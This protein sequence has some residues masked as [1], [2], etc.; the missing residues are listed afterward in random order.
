[1][2]ESFFGPNRLYTVSGASTDISKFGH[3]VFAWYIHRDL[4]AIPINPK[5]SSIL[6]IPTIKN[7]LE[8]SPTT[9]N[10]NN[11]ISIIEEKFQNFKNISSAL[12]SLNSG[13]SN[14]STATATTTISISVITPPHVSSKLLQD[15]N[16]DP[17]LKP[18]VKAIW[19]QPG[20]FDDNVLEL[21]KNIGIP[22][23]IA[24]GD[25]ILV[26]GQTALDNARRSESWNILQ[27]N[28]KKDNDKDDDH[29][30]SSSS[31]SRL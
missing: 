28:I 7:I 26:Q 3:K 6:G 16:S 23:I 31:P 19:F 9:N 27:K 22:T 5:A 4:A 8:L 1:M 29:G 2:L 14:K 20:T 11:N 17:L 30:D 21:A 12:S 15:I 24:H 18:L 10:N 25:C 13:A